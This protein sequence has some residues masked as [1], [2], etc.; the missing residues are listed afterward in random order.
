MRNYFAAIL[1]AALTPEQAAE[2]IGKSARSFAN[3]RKRDDFP[4]PRDM[5]GSGRYLVF[6]RAELD[7]WLAALPPAPVAP[8]PAQLKRSRGRGADEG[9]DP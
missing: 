8:E 9:V 5:S 4:T 7:A 3:L 6:L 1:P 2:Y